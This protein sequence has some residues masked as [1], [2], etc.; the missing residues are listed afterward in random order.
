MPNLP[1]EFG[2]ADDVMS[3]L[4]DVHISGMA[5]ELVRIPG[6]F[7]DGYTYTTGQVLGRRT[8]RT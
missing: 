1:C 4:H 2:L 5:F 7:V 3:T 8:Y 6:Y